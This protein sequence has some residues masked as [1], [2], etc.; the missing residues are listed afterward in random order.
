MLNIWVEAVTGA[1]RWY[2]YGYDPGPN[3]MMRFFAA[4]AVEKNCTTEL[5]LHSDAVNN[6]RVEL[7]T[8][9]KIWKSIAVEI[10]VYMPLRSHLIVY[11]LRLVNH[12]SGDIL[13]S[14]SLKTIF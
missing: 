13:F 8:F 6:R 14:F 11:L 2:G 12:I 7:R 10:Q 4:T 9:N 1:T 3:K 5:N